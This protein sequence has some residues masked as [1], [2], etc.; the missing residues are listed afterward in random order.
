MAKIDAQIRSVKTR[1]A[2][3]G[4]YGVVQCAPATIPTICKYEHVGKALFSDCCP[5]RL[6]MLML[7]LSPLAKFPGPK[8]AAATLWYEFYYDAVRRGRYTFKIKELH[9]KYVAQREGLSISLS[10]DFANTWEQ[11]RVTGK[12]MPLSLGYT[13]LA[14]DLI[15]SYVLDENQQWLDAP[16]WLPH[17]R[18]AL[19]TLSEM[20]MVSRQVTWLLEILKHFP[21]AW[22]S[23]SNPGLGLFFEL[24]ERFRR[25]IDEIQI[26]RG[27]GSQRVETEISKGY[28]LIDQI[29]D[30]NL[31]VEEKT[32]ERILQ[33]IRSTTAAGIETTSNA[34]TVITYHLLDNPDKLQK[35]QNELSILEDGGNSEQQVHELGKLPYLVC[36]LVYGTQIDRRLRSSLRDCGN[37]GQWK[38]M[39]SYGVST[40]LQRKSPEQ[41]IQY[42]NYCIPPGTP[43]GMT[44]VLMHHNETIFPNSC[45]FVPER[46]LD[47]QERKRLERYLVSFGKGSRRCVGQRLAQT[48]LLIAIATIFRKFELQLWGTLKNDIEI[49]HDLFVPR[50]KNTK[51]IGL[52]VRVLKKY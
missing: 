25:K 18:W 50:P 44:S 40:R 4:T 47:L 52:Q 9:Q 6:Q 24:E 39:L 15:V 51:S 48:T 1:L 19:R 23:S 28:T 43:V 22:V 37:D 21:R 45:K 11:F 27:K 38:V 12:T 5:G 49:S 7:Y 41:A 34:L 13:C 42:K 8:L 31:E 10:T 29:L 16:E 17:W 35:L 32:P 20:V 33:E 2:L 26:D 46:W 36:L 3:T 30:S 14:T